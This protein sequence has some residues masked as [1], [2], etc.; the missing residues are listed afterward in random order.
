MLS[1]G[2]SCMPS[3]KRVTFAG[4]F[5]ASQCTKGVTG[6]ASGSSMITAYD[7][8]F[9]TGFHASA[10]GTPSAYSVNG[11]GMFPS[12]MKEVEV[13]SSCPEACVSARAEANT[14]GAA[15]GGGS[16]S[17]GAAG[18]PAPGPAYET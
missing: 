13:T 1:R 8:T 3:G 5:Q 15:C 7:T 16:A 10:G 14:S 11:G 17:Y 12:A 6:L 4:M 18:A 9:G 2:C